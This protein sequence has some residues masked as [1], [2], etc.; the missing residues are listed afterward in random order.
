VG[1]LF[2]VQNLLHQLFFGD[3]DLHADDSRFWP[4]DRTSLVAVDRPI[5]RP[6]CLIWA[7]QNWEPFA[8]LSIDLC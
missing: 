7:V 8:L 2:W 6:T 4:T 1:A 3:K 5:R